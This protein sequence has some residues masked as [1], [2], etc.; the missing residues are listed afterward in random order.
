MAASLSQM[1][2]L[3]ILRTIASAIKGDARGATYAVSGR[4][5]VK[6]SSDR[7]D[8]IDR[9]NIEGGL[10]PSNPIQIRFDEGGQGVKLTLPIT[11]TSL[12]TPSLK[13]HQGQSP[14][15]DP[16]TIPLELQRLLSAAT[17][18]SLVHGSQH[19]QNQSTGQLSSDDFLTS[20]C[21]YNTGIVDVVQQIML[22]YGLLKEGD[23]GIRAELCELAICSA[24]CGP[25]K[26]HLSPDRSDKL[27]GRLIVA[28]PVE[29]QGGGLV[30]RRG[31][32]EIEREQVFDWSQSSTDPPIIQW[33]A[34]H[35][36]CEH[37][38]LEVASGHLI[39][40]T[41]DLFSQITTGHLAGQKSVLDPTRLPLYKTLSTAL[42]SPSFLPRGAL[43]VV[44]LW[45]HYAH[46]SPTHN[47]LP[48]SLKS[49]EMALYE[50]AGA[51]RL[52]RYV[53]PLC[54]AR[55][56]TAA[57][58]YD[59]GQR[60]MLLGRRFVPIEEVEFVESFW[61]HPQIM[62]EY[63]E[64]QD[65]WED[66]KVIWLNDPNPSTMLAQAVFYDH[67][68]GNDHVHGESIEYT[69]AI[70]LI[71]VPPFDARGQMPVEGQ[72]VFEGIGLLEEGADDQDVEEGGEED[73]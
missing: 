57:G 8:G 44:D 65:K 50:V 17:T 38:V 48:H 28:L 72:G 40:L 42:D 39:T 41:Y 56:E 53:R 19:K 10:R 23:R 26:T 9:H 20:F 45:H 47:C 31:G 29:H 60:T 27:I 68:S 63:L 58:P 34:F 13:P 2:E 62:H 33:A 22:P 70:M 49:A 66:G 11:K 12:D 16:D 59:D 7:D 15:K 24:P 52:Q 21:P 55:E 67:D 30:V 71:K 18:A 43:L 54:E 3:V 46:T 61:D 4:I 37:E 1:T 25:S 35:S 14:T 6:P 69:R 51:L 64:V 5:P 36:D 32:E 73:G